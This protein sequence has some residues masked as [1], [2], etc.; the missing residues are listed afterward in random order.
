[1]AVN[2]VIIMYLKLSMMRNRVVCIAVC[3]VNIL[4]FSFCV[5]IPLRS[6]AIK[7]KIMVISIWYIMEKL[8]LIA[9]IVFS[10]GL[11]LFKSK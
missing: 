3:F 6:V 1:M 4:S 11:S 2:I 10:F 9:I 5:S 7:L 8:A